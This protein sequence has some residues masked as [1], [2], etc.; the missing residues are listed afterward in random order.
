[1][2]I[3]KYFRDYIEKEMYALCTNRPDAV[4]I[5]PNCVEC[6]WNVTL[7][8]HEF[9]ANLTEHYLYAVHGININLNDC[10]DLDIDSRISHITRDSYN[11]GN[12]TVQLCKDTVDGKTVLNVVITKAFPCPNEEV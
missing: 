3:T 11:Y 6:V 4:R 5:Y 9:F 2:L 12:M 1:M 7:E 10:E 8:L